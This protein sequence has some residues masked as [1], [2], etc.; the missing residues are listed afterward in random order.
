MNRYVLCIFV[1]AYCLCL[2]PAEWLRIHGHVNATTII[3]LFDP[4]VWL[5]DNGLM[6]EW[7]ATWTLLWMG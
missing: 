3:L 2:G 1:L 5:I 6:P 7:L 4:L